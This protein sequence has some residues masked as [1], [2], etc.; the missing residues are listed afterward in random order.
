MGA[1]PFVVPQPVDPT[2]KKNGVWIGILVVLVLLL[3]SIIAFILFKLY[4]DKD[5]AED[6][7][8]ALVYS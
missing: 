3:I 2:T 4:S 6:Q 5:D 1:N 7:A 8:S